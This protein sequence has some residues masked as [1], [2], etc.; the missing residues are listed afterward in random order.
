MS[1]SP[2][3]PREVLDDLRRSD[4]SLADAKRSAIE[5]LP[6]KCAQGFSKAESAAYRLPYFELNGKIN[7]F[8]RLRYLDP[9][10]TGRRYTQPPDSGCHLYFS[11][12]VKRAWPEIAAADSSLSIYFTEGEKKAACACKHGLPTIGLGGVD[13]WRGEALSELDRFELTGRKLFIVFDSDRQTNS[14]VIRAERQFAAEL[15][16]RGARVYAKVLPPG[17]NGE[18]VGLDDFLVAHGRKA[19]DAL[20]EEEIG[21]PEH[22]TDL[23]NARRLVRLHGADLRYNASLG[24]LVW[25]GVRWR[26]DDTGEVERCAKSTIAAMYSEAARERDDDRRRALAKCAAASESVGR[27]RAMIELA[28]SEPC[29]HI[30]AAALDAEPFLFGVENGVIDLRTGELQS[31]HREDYIT[32]RAP[33]AYDPAARAPRWLRFL[34]EVFR[35][36]VELTK[37]VHRAV[38]YALTGDVREQC[39]FF[40][41]GHGA[42]GKSVFLETV[43]ALL[44][45]YAANARTETIMARQRGGEIPNDVARLAGVRLVTVNEVEEGARLNESLVKDLTGG[46]TLTARFLHREYFE[47][48]AQFKLWVRGNHKPII[49]G[50]DDGIWRRVRLVPF[51]AT[52]PEAKQDRQLAEK[53]RSELPGILNWAIEGCLAWQRDGLTTPDAVKIATEGYRHESDLLGTWIEECC[54]TGE[55]K[56]EAAGVLY[57]LYSD[58]AKDSGLQPVS[59]VTFSRALQERGFEKKVTKGN[60]KVYRGLRPRNPGER[61]LEKSDKEKKWRC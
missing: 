33:V 8:H 23:G 42:N 48:R 24:W 22:M 50:T 55:G 53:L 2:K 30:D 1:A 49:R 60:I 47:F 51:E 56:K 54:E 36:D 6:G 21:A 4:L 41:Y 29:I 20:P 19:F 46:D 14:H 44:D 32:K 31:G 26:R 43:H 40:A 61:I 10:L 34:K 17:P 35:N 3:L 13:N 28:R 27:I 58:W 9:A 18:K 57:Q 5:Y 59:Q 7:G 12:L 16:L 45:E 11:P 15:R 25:D 38:G 37:Y 39:L 52:F